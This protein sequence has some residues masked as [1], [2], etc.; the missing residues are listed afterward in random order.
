[1]DLSRSTFESVHQRAQLLD[2]LSKLVNSP[3]GVGDVAQGAFGIAVELR[4]PSFEPLELGA[5]D[6]RAG[7]TL[8]KEL[9]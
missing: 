8:L 9:P 2:V 4:K 7:A 5:E 1:M 6:Q 3:K